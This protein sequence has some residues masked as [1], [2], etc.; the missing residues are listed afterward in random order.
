MK[1][2]EDAVKTA[3]SAED[4]K[5]AHGR[6]KEAKAA[7]KEVLEDRIESKEALLG[8]SR[9]KAVAVVKESKASD[10]VLDILD[11]QQQE[12]DAKKLKEAAEKKEADVQKVLDK[13]D[14]PID[15]EKIHTKLLDAKQHKLEAKATLKKAKADIEVAKKDLDDKEAMQPSML[16]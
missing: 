4:E 7:Y 10:K 16:N 6:L 1:K 13:A 15:K 5:K 2:A 11:A 12:R 8:A 9:K 3:T 14:D